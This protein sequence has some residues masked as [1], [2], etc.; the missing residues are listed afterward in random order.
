MKI[1]G[2]I[3]RGWVGRQANN[4]GRESVHRSLIASACV[5]GEMFQKLSLA[6][7]LR[8]HYLAELA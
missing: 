2:L 8:F 4:A 6:I 1:C 7:V 3:R 5:G